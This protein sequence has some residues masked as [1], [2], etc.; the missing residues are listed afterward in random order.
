MISLVTTFIAGF[1]PA[2]IAVVAGSVWLSSALTTLSRRVSIRAG[3]MGMITALG[4]VSPEITSAVTALV[5]GEHEVGLGVVLGS[6]LFNLA[7]LL[8]LT[9]VLAGRVPLPRASMVFNGA[10]SL[11]ATSVVALLIYRAISPAFSFGLLVLILAGYTLVLRCPKGWLRTSRIPHLISH[12]LDTMSAILHDH[13]RRKNQ[14]A[15]TTTVRKKS[16]GWR[17]AAQ[18]AAALL[19]IVL[20]SMGIVHTTLP[21]AEAWGIP[22]SLVGALILAALT[23]IPNAYTAAQLSRQKEGAAVVSE[24]LNSNTINLVA[25]IGLPVL[26]FGM[27]AKEG[28]AILEIWWLLGLT[29]LAV[30]LPSLAGAITRR[31]GVTIIGVYM[32]F[33]VVRVVLQ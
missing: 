9:G 13:A 21:I 25:G 22:R 32:L 17:L 5:A 31:A 6:N 16:S 1:L 28:I 2:L 15:A 18:V 3:L 8:G 26:V 4:A 27:H 14:E 29:G 11:G 33:V 24:T 19:L 23:G 7:G 20:G 12:P 10:V 30:L